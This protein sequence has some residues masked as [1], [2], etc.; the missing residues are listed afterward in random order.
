M[1]YLD[2]IDPEAAAQ[3][4]EDARE[5]R[6][7]P[8]TRAAW[9]PDAQP[10]GVVPEELKGALGK[11]LVSAA[12]ASGRFHE[13]SPA[14]PLPLDVDRMKMN[15]RLTA[16]DLACYDLLLSIAR[17]TPDDKEHRYRW[18]DLA[19]A[20]GLDRP[21]DLEDVFHR[22]QRANVSY[23]IEYDDHVGVADGIPLM[24]LETLIHGGADKIAKFSI[25]PA[26][27]RVLTHG[28]QYQ[29]TELAPLM[30][31]K[32]Q[33]SGRLYKL[34]LRGVHAAGIGALG[35]DTEFTDTPE[36]LA[37]AMDWRCVGDAFSFKDFRRRCLEPAIEDMRN[38]KRLHVEID[39]V[40][41]DGRG[42]PVVGIRFRVRVHP[43]RRETL[44]SHGL[45]PGSMKYFSP[46]SGGGRDDLPEYRVMPRVWFRGVSLFT[47]QQWQQWHQWN[48]EQMLGHGDRQRLLADAWQVALKRAIEGDAEMTW[49]L[50]D[51]KERGA[52]AAAEG[53]LRR[54]AERPDWIITPMLVG[55]EEDRSE[56]WEAHDARKNRICD[57]EPEWTE[58]NT[59]NL[60]RKPRPAVEPEPDAEEV[61]SSATDAPKP[62][63]RG[64]PLPGAFKPQRVKIP[65]V[66]P[67]TD[68]PT[69]PEPEYDE[70]QDIEVPSRVETWLRIHKASAGHWA[71]HLHSGPRWRRLRVRDHLLHIM[72]VHFESGPA[73]VRDLLD[74]DPETWVEAA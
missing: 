62:A 16:R 57:A 13:V 47:E 12:V 9:L 66:A 39:Y 27:M 68:E 44:K 65:E 29:H 43:A 72:R 17:E 63:R 54:M 36:A 4:V 34:L 64:V 71:A 46:Y 30:A 14:V 48:P 37:E 42:R 52:D 38:L 7:L 56:R 11:N 22:L 25:P 33:W 69:A 58:R 53:F 61:E 18:S 41:G 23:R 20:I 70:P 10:D 3:L 55:C 51:I 67:A 40:R 74:E 35:G 28:G 73:R 50:G 31:F 2:H 45:G 32:C 21:S 59:P 24:T 8:D 1:S 6:A 19:K 49:L 5:M 60:R 26:T 15:G